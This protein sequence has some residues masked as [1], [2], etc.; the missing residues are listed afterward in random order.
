MLVEILVNHRATYFF[1]FWLAAAM[2]Y[3]MWPKKKR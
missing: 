1:L 2:V 3:N